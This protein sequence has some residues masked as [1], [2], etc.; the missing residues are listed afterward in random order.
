M[1]K[2]HQEIFFEFL[3]K[4]IIVGEDVLEI[5]SRHSEN[6]TLKEDITIINY[7]IKKDRL[8]IIKTRDDDT[9]LSYFMLSRMGRLPEDCWTN[10][11]TGNTNWSDYEK[12]NLRNIATQV[13]KQNDKKVRIVSANYLQRLS[14]LIEGKWLNYE[15]KTDRLSLGPRFLG[16]MRRWLDSDLPKYQVFL[17][18]LSTCC[19]AR[20][21]L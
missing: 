15:K 12:D 19:D 3:E 13:L 18:L 2:S 7:F 16:Q 4:E 6:R 1:D 14:R 17:F 9:G 11:Q 5:H 21:L 20:S 8:V 10:L